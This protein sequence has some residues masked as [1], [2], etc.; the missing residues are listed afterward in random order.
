MGDQPFP[1][2]ARK[3]ILRVLFISLLL[4]LVSLPVLQSTIHALQA[5][6]TLTLTP[7]DI[8]HLHP[9]PLPPT[10]LL[11]PQPRSLLLHQPIRNFNSLPHPP[12]PHPSRPK[13]LQ[14]LLRSPNLLKIRHCPPR[15]RPRLPLLPLP[16]HRLTHNRPPV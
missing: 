8:I 10:N 12:C 15:R 6:N 5:A 2:A 1:P 3:K 7:P 13:R 4:D 11:L 9:P 16:S 14:I